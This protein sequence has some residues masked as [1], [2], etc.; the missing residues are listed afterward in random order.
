MAVIIVKEDLSNVTFF[1][2]Q[3]LNHN[4]PDLQV[5]PTRSPETLRLFSLL[6]WQKRSQKSGKSYKSLPFVL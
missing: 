6:G 5:L 3:H 2:W 4:A 1:G